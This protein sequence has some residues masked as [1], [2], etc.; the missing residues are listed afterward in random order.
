MSTTSR[1]VPYHLIQVAKGCLFSFL[2]QQPML[3]SSST[4]HQNN[5]DP[6]GQGR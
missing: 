5:Y 6:K 3:V 2:I 1:F 4:S